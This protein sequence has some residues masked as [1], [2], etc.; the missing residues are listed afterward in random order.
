M[1]NSIKIFLTIFILLLLTSCE[2]EEV[3]STD[4]VHIEYAVVQS[5]LQ[6]DKIYEGVRFTKTLP[7]GIPYDIKIAELK[8]I[9]AYVLINSVQIIPLVYD[10]D[11]WYRTSYDVYP[12]AGDTFEL[13]A[14]RDGKFIYA[15]TIIPSQPQVTNARYNQ[16]S[17][18]LDAR[19]NT[20]SSEVYA[21]LWIIA[22]TNP[23]KARDYFSVSAGFSGENTIVRTTVIPEEY[24]G[25]NY[26]DS[27]FIQVF[28]F[29]KSFEKYFNSRAAN[30]DI[31]DP[32]IQGGGEIQWNVQGDKV[33]GMFI[34]IAESLPI[35]AN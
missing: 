25:I 21:A 6:I 15:K 8:N 2:I 23:L 1:K 27:R 26:N 14:D 19:V 18:Y 22:G 35:K 13:F 34:G 4:Q 5:E 17:Y 33:I 20:N 28:A 3:I 30:N 7:L 12:K 9:I 10:Y 16:G 31:S 29:D 32:F 11:G 24:R